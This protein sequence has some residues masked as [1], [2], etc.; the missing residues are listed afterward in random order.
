MLRPVVKPLLEQATNALQALRRS[1]RAHE[2]TRCRRLRLTSFF[3]RSFAR[4]KKLLG[5]PGITTR[6]PGTAT[7]SKDATRDMKLLGGPMKF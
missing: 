6:N 4:N 5:A 2:P 3:C 7:R 1:R